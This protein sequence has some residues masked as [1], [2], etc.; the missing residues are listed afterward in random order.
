MKQ[1]NIQFPLRMLGLI[2][3]LFLSVSAFAQIEV[4]GHVKDATG[5]A[6]IGAT[7]RVDGTQDATI[8]DFDGN[9]VLKAKEGADITVSYIGYQQATV[10]AAP[11]VV[12]LLQD[13]AAL[14]N[15]VVVIGAFSSIGFQLFRCKV[16][17][18]FMNNDIYLNIIILNRLCKRLHFRIISFYA[19]K[20]QRNKKKR[21]FAP[22]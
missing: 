15:E 6:I 3:G 17:K 18:K 11:S 19:K 22:E 7:V 9:F 16:T 4:K 10:K 21:N 14:L 13:D 5:E 12:V 2:L 8:T 1:V 20:V